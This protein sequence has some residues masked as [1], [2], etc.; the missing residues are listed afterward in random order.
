MEKDEKKGLDYYLEGAERG[1]ALAFANA[2]YAYENGRGTDKNPELALQYYLKDAVLGE[3]H[4]IEAVKRYDK[5][6]NG[7]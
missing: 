2:G 5:M 7:K 6:M 3:E 4:C 1:D